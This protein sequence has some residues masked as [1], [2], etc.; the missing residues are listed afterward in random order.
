MKKQEAQAD[1]ETKNAT[2]MELS[3]G[4]TRKG[5]FLWQNLSFGTEA[6]YDLAS[7]R[8]KRDGKRS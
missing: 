8:G 7:E 6:R 1:R 5:G 4:Y 3:Y 2:F